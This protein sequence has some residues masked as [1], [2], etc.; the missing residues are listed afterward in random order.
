MLETSREVFGN[1]PISVKV[2]FYIAAAI[3]G[4]VFFI[5][6][7]LKVSIW[8]KGRDDPFDAISKKSFLGLI[9]TSILYIFSKD[10]LFAQRVMGKSKLRGVMLIFVYWGFIILFIGT[11]I[12]AIDYDI[13]LHILKGQ[14][15]L[16]YSLVLDIAGGL[17][18]MSLSFYILRRYIFSRQA[19]VSDWD[20]A[21]VLVLLFLVVLS[22][23]CIEGARLARL[24]PPSMD[25]SPVGAV[26]VL[27][28]K[29]FTPQEAT[30][31]ILHRVFWIF[32]AF[33]ALVFIAYIPFSKQ[34]HMFAAQITTLEASRRNSRLWEI[35]HE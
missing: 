10:C 17:A 20:D 3:S 8:L 30:L 25:W 35:I 7:W 31:K 5:G 29:T 12:V 22:G 18:L 19:V 26:F 16:I 13:G 32:H 11:V 27:I 28:F 2:L 4:A 34:F 9:K 1:I 21:V 15:Y 23:F 24:G 33:F 14:F 6:S